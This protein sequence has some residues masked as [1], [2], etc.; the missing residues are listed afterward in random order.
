MFDIQLCGY[1]V[2]S[3]SGEC[4]H[5]FHRSGFFENLCSFVESEIFVVQERGYSQITQIFTD[6]YALRIVPC[7]F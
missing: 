7:P 6:V 3:G 1:L 4:V 5:R 2:V